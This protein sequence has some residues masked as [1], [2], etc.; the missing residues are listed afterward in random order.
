MICSYTESQWVAED[1]VACYERDRE[2]QV[3]K[4]PYMLM[5]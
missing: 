5:Q 4:A 1:V 2:I 3:Q